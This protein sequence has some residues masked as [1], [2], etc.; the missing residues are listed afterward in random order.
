MRAIV[1]EPPAGKPKRRPRYAGR[2]PSRFA[3]KYKE[4]APDRYPEDFARVMAA[5]KTPAGTHRPIMVRE[6][7]EILAPQPGDFTIDCTLGY[8]GHAQ[9]LLAATQPGGRLMGLDVDPVELPKTEMR[10]RALG[11]GPDTFTV[12][13]TNY[14]GLA[15][16]LP[17]T[18]DIILADLGLSSMQ[19]D[20][21]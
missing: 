16:V 10:F 3:E 21:P 13:Q 1:T 11:F 4:H 14:A 5:G 18:A 9:A 6:I 17:E 2:N 8:G 19:I 15:R 12:H 20:N 7:L